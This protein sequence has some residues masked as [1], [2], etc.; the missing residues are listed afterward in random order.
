MVGSLV[1]AFA[2]ALTHDRFENAPGLNVCRSQR[3]LPF[4][5]V[6]PVVPQASDVATVG[7]R[8]VVEQPE[9][10][11]AAIP[12]IVAPPRGPSLRISSTQFLRPG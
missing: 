4:D 7:G 3:P 1:L 2:E 5:L 10:R 12:L 6:A 9:L 11:I 8:D